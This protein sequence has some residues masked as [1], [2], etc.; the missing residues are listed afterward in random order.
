MREGSIRVREAVAPGPSPGEATEEDWKPGDQ[1]IHPVFGPGMVKAL[2]GTGSTLK[3]RVRFDKVGEK[4]LVA[5]LARLRK[6]APKSHAAFR[7]KKRR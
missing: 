1:V 4:L 6:G 7:G 5:R 2:E 3:V